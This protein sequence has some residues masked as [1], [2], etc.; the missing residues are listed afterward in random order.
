MET[1]ARY[2]LVGL[3][4]LATALTLVGFVVW[5]AAFGSQIRYQPYYVRFAGSVSQLRANTTVLFGGIPVGRVVDVGIDSQ[6]SELAL[7]TIEVREG[8]P[9][10]VDSVA[11]L[12][13]QSLAGGV[14]MQIS[15]GSRELDLLPSG[16]EI[17]ATPSALERLARQVPD[18][19]AKIDDLADRFGLFLT[20]ENA[21]NIALTLANAQRLSGELAALA[22]KLDPG[23]LNR[24]I[25]NA[26]AAVQSIRSAAEQ[27]RETARELSATAQK[28]G[29]KAADAAAQVSAVARSIARTSDG[30]AAA[31]EENREPLKQ[32][33]GTALYD[34]SELVTELRRLVQSLTRISHQVEKDPARFFL[35][36]R[37]KGVEAQ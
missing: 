6:N 33:S 20:E 9:V 16:S 27:M 5:L 19:I 3:F 7:V 15:R 24:T 23:A 17:R 12:E 21:N 1:K 29:G 18:L 36:D 14:V 2:F 13:V 11:S 35:G 32:F 26:D 28:L 8:T 34:V 30:L 37:A 31:I 22:E 25:D 4:V 10:R